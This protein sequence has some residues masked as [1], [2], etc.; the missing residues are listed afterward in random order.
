VADEEFGRQIPFGF[1]EKIK[2]DFLKNYG[3][4]AKNAVAMSLQRVY[5]R[6]RR[7]GA[8]ARHAACAAVRAGALAQ[9]LRACAPAVA[10]SPS[11]RA[12]SLVASK[13]TSKKPL[14]LCAARSGAAL[15]R[16]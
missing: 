4:S 3:E 6:V 10:L 9:P 12:H 11:L 1:L 15:A 16:R 7:A 8:R 14:G 13:H 5:R 2:D